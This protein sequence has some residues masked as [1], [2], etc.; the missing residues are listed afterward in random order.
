L[1]VERLIASNVKSYKKRIAVSSLPR[2]EGGV[3]KCKKVLGGGF[4]KNPTDKGS[5]KEG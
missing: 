1:E 3:R 2:E 4:A 5:R